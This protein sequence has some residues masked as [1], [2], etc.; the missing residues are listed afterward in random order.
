ML[1]VQHFSSGSIAFCG[2]DCHN[3]AKNIPNKRK[4][5]A[6]VKLQLSLEVLAQAISS[7]DLTEKR[8]S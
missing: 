3:G 7:L 2:G 5:P 1:A 8:N 4:M 6:I